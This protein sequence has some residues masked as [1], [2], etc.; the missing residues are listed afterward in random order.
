MGV[1]NEQPGV[2]VRLKRDA[3]HTTRNDD[4]LRQIRVRVPSSSAYHLSSLACALVV[5]VAAE[6]HTPPQTR[7]HAYSTR[8]LEREPARS[9]EKSFPVHSIDSLILLLFPSDDLLMSTT[10]SL[11]FQAP[12]PSAHTGR[13]IPSIPNISR[14]LCALRPITSPSTH[15][16]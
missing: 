9:A 6:T 13:A 8:L 3:R 12:F 11:S 7:A 16:A 2:C 1:R 4:G 14:A 15:S 10:R 5:A